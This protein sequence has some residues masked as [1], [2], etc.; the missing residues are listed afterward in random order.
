M[1]EENNIQDLVDQEYEECWRPMIEDDEGNI[2]KGQLKRELFDFSTLIHNSSEII[3][4]VT[5]DRL[6]KPLTKPEHVIEFA[7]L[8]ANIEFYDHLTEELSGLIEEI[9]VEFKESSDKSDAELRVMKI[10]NDKLREHQISLS[11]IE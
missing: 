4:R 3:C 6:S 11:K 1:T 9:E 2:N 10:L 7:E 5:G 8:K